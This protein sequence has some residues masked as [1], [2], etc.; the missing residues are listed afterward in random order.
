VVLGRQCV[1][2]AGKEF[3]NHNSNWTSQ[4]VASFT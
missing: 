1:A 4:N 3:L 2:E